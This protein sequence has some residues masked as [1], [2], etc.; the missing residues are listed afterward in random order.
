MS[1]A[2]ESEDTGKEALSRTQSK[3]AGELQSGVG[4]EELS[5]Q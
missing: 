5:E 2:Q 3:K 4:L 1:P